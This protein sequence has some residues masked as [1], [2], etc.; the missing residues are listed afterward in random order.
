MFTYSPAETKALRDAAT[1]FVFYGTLLTVGYA[2]SLLATLSANWKVGPEQ[3]R[4]VQFFWPIIYVPLCL[5]VLI[6]PHLAIHCVICR[7]KD[8]LIGSCQDRLNKLLLTD[9]MTSEAVD[10]SNA[11]A[12]F[13]EKI[14]DTPDYALDLSIGVRTVVPAAFNVATLFISRDQLV[15]WS[16][17]VLSGLL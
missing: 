3:A 8:R 9:P 15:E 6:V 17:D 11:L 14:S 1:Y 7:E 12:D 16:K 5:S 2:F 13:F 4:V 10:Q